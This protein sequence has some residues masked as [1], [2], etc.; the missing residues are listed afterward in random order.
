MAEAHRER[1]VAPGANLDEA[2]RA[3][4]LGRRHLASREYERAIRC[5]RRSYVLVPLPAAAALLRQAQA[6]CA[7][8]PAYCASCYRFRRNC[9]CGGSEGSAAAA[10]AAAAASAAAA[11]H[12]PPRA[13]SLSELAHD[14]LHALAAVGNA[15]IAALAPLFRAVGLA[16]ERIPRAVAGLV[17]LLLLAALRA[18]VGE[19]LAAAWARGGLHHPAAAA[20]A[21]GAGVGERRRAT[22]AH[23]GDGSGS[24]GSGGGSGGGGSGG[25]SGGMAASSLTTSLLLSA[26]ATAALNACAWGWRR[27]GGV[28][29]R[30]PQPAGRG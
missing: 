13:P 6:A 17:L 19:P 7:A 1:P 21:A 28:G 8:D 4:D 2:Q 26:G 25:G 18:M 20:A 22:G 29:V 10:A 3:L 15:V 23:G 11:A 5:I 16:E 30:A 24:G 12:A 27:G 14:G 9:S